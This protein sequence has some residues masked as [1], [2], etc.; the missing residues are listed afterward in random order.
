MLGSL[1]LREHL[2]EHG[3]QG[4]R[5]L[6]RSPPCGTGSRLGRAPHADPAPTLHPPHPPFPPSSLAAAQAADVAHSVGDT[7]GQAVEFVK[8]HLPEVHVERQG[9]PRLHR[10]LPCCL[11]CCCAGRPG[12]KLGRRRGPG[13]AAPTP[14]CPPDS[15]PED[16]TPEERESQALLDEAMAL[17]TGEAVPIRAPPREVCPAVLGRDRRPRLLHAK[18]E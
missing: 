3:R 16:T 13:A 9:A 11:L 17:A 15:P 18:G 7:L 10:L 14:C 1:G 2:G 6:W 8:G 4:P 12:L 5:R